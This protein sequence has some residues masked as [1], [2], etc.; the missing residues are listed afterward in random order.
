MENLDDP[1]SPKVSKLLN[2]LD[3]DW[4]CKNY[5]YGHEKTFH[6]AEKKAYAFEIWTLDHFDNV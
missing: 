6:S 1:G 5:P 3:T 4:D 2:N